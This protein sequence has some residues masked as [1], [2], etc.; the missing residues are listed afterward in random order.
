MGEIYKDIGKGQG[1]V[2][3]MSEGYCVGYTEMDELQTIENLEIGPMNWDW[4]QVK[5]PL[6]LQRVD[7]I[8]ISELIRD[9]ELITKK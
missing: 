6:Q 4:E 5:E 3:N 2:L 1:I 7:P 9:M 8:I